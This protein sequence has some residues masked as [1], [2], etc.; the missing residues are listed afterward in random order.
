M[1]DIEN[2]SASLKEEMLQNLPLMIK[3]HFSMFYN[4][5]VMQIKS[6][7]K[8]QEMRLDETKQEQEMRQQTSSL[9]FIYFP[10]CFILKIGNWDNH[11]STI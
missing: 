3:N 10:S 1:A 5:A 7:M 9:S 6:N 8:N 2:I 4:A 11:G